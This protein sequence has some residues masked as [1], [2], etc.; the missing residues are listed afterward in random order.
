MGA[1][2]WNVIVSRLRLDMRLTLKLLKVMSQMSDDLILFL[3]CF[4]LQDRL[5]LGLGEIILT[6]SGDLMQ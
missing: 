5:S 1:V 3:Q 4:S 2:H 6:Q